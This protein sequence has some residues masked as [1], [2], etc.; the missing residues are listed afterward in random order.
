MFED[1][2]LKIIASRSF[3]WHYLPTKYHKNLPSGSKLISGGETDT[4][5]QT[6]W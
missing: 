6:D 1:K 5:T 3:I 4:H 2:G